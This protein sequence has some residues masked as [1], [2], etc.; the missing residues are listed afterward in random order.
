MIRIMGRDR[1]G[2]TFMV[3][4]ATPDRSF[5]LAREHCI[6]A[7]DA[8]TTPIS[9]SST[10]IWVVIDDSCGSSALTFVVAKVGVNW[11]HMTGYGASG[12]TFWK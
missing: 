6:I 4:P 12:M 10:A 2:T 8:A 7:M 11:A 3:E 9:G 5:E 1:V